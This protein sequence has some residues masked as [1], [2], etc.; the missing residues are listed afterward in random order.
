MKKETA[1]ML[2]DMR[3]ARNLTQEQLGILSGMTKSQ[4]S[5][6][7]KGTLGSEDTVDRLFEAMGFE[8][9][10]RLHD[11]YMQDPQGQDRV[12]N[13]L[14]HFKKY[15][16]EKYGIESL[17]LFGSFA[18][19]EQREESDVDILIALKKPSLYIMAEIK[20]TLRSI[21]KR[22]VDLVSSKVAQRQDFFSKIS[23]DLIYV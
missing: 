19:N 17:A 21:L 11:K 6:M 14:R 16:A 12:L 5:K 23:N 2:H 15:N 7:E 10:V 4:I 20:E 8:L 9:E 18:R 3:K 1:K 22:N 13:T